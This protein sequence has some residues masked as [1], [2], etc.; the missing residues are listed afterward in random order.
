LKAEIMTM[1]SS[2]AITALQ[3]GRV[4]HLTTL[5]A[6]GTP[7]TTVVWVD[8][9]RNQ[10]IIGKLM[11]DV[12]TRN[13]RRDPRVTVSM[14]ADGDQWGMANYIVIEG[15]AEVTEGGAPELLQHLAHRYIGPNAV[16]PP[17]DN[18]PPG[19]VLRITPTKV[20]GMGPWGTHF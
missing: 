9:D 15:T 2:E 7:H 12:K 16:F 14:E 1:L 6:D 19:F 5:R 10:I 11:E 4:A 13:I 3:S 17:M 8:V 18:P 20:R